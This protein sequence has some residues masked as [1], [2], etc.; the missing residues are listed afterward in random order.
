[1]NDH[2]IN[3]NYSCSLW[4]YDFQVG[5]RGVQLSG[6]Q[7][8]RIAIARAILKNPPILLLDE[9]TSALDSESEKLVQEALEKAME[10]RTVILIAHRLSTIVNADMIAVVENGQVT[11]T[12]EHN[13]LLTTSKFYNMLF[14]MQTLST[15][16]QRFVKLYTSIPFQQCRGLLFLT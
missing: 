8:Q 12:G 16:N 2:L 9:A 3:H 10:G 11:E 6:G 5:E 15:S 13:S 7:K 14:S 4:K 1:M